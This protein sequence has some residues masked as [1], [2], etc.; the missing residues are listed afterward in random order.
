MVLL[1]SCEKE[2]FNKIQVGNWGTEHAS[3]TVNQLSW[4]FE[5]DCA[6][7]TVQEPVTFS[8]GKFETDALYYRESGV[9]LD[10]P[11]FYKAI[12]SKVSGSLLSND[13][14]ELTMLVG[15]DLENYGTYTFVYDQEGNVYKCP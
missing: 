5:F 15:P 12:P 14:L 11:D 8:D 13:K 1:F 9:Q 6:N 4:Y 2:T 3:L 7:V 10:D